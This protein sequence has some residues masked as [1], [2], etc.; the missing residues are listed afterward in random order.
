M[1]E[2]LLG[3]W[4]NDEAG[5]LTAAASHVGEAGGAEAGEAPSHFAAEN[6]GGKIDQHVAHFNA[7]ACLH[8]E[9][10]S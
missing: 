8:G 3:F 5:D 6:V 10:V 7:V 4:F 9:N 1:T 2:K